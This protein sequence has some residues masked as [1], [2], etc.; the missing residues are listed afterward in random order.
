MGNA[1]PVIQA[2]LVAAWFRRKR[3]EAQL[4]AHELGRM[5]GAQP[6]GEIDEADDMDL[7]LMGFSIKNVELK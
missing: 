4:I 6:A 7:A 5:L 1:D 2:R 3:L